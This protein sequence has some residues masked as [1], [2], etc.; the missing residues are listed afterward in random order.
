VVA[1]ALQK[2]VT[3]DFGPVWQITGTV[4]AFETLETV[5]VDYWPVVIRD[6]INEPGAAGFQRHLGIYRHLLPI[7]NAFIAR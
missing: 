2:Q 7:I 6:N 1:A 4:D 3:R 5:P